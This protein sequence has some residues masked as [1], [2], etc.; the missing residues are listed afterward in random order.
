MRANE[1]KI[2]AQ[3]IQEFAITNFRVLTIFFRKRDFS[4]N[5]KT[6]DIRARS[7]ETERQRQRSKERDRDKKKQQRRDTRHCSS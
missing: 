1:Q 5:K 6:P 4:P 2:K 3:C 7:K